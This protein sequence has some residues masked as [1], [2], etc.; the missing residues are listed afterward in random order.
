MPRPQAKDFTPKKYRFISFDI[1]V[2]ADDNPIAMLL[3]SVHTSDLREMGREQIAIDAESDKQDINRLR[4]IVK[5][6]L[7][8]YEK[9][10]GY[11]RI[12]NA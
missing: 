6:V 11:E 10:T 2:D 8:N 5:K 12:P 4:Q 7:G 1:T 9:D 3:V